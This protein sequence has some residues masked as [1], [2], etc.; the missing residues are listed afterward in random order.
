MH[1]CNDLTSGHIIILVGFGSLNN[2]N[3]IRAQSPHINPHQY[4]LLVK[5]W[6]WVS[7]C[8][9]G[10]VMSLCRLT[11]VVELGVLQ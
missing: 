5:T 1:V 4:A 3:S 9:L 8:G 11:L 7:H 10:K 2:V 6:F